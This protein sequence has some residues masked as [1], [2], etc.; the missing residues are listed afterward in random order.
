MIMIRTFLLLG[1]NLGDRQDYLDKARV[2]LK[3]RVGKM[4][5]ISSVYQTAAWGNT[6]QQAFLNQVI[7]VETKLTPDQLLVVIQDIE[8]SLGRTREGKWAAR[9]LDIDILFYGDKIMKHEHLTI[10]HPEIA[11]RRF[12]LEPMMEIEPEFVHPVLKKTIQKLL[13]ICPDMLPVEIYR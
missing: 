9:T 13:A 4:V 11:N 5:A 6:E 12:T 7:G 8:N 3:K 1:S 2:L 10:P